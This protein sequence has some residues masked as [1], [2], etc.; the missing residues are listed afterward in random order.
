ME[1]SY[2]TGKCVWIKVVLCRCRSVE[3]FKNIPLIF[4]C[5][6][7]GII[8]SCMVT[9]E[10]NDQRCLTIDFFF[11]Q[12]LLLK[13]YYLNGICLCRGHSWNAKNPFLHTIAECAKPLRAFVLLYVWPCVGKSHWK[14]SKL[15]YYHSY[16]EKRSS[17]SL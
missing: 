10:R 9:F 17:L 5:M 12:L 3:Q 6:V 1:V 2:V 15:W 11:V 7:T 13:M 4:S 8:F 16:H 14:L